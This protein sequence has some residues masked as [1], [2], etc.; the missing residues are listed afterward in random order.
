MA[1][2]FSKIINREIPAEIVYEDEQTLAFLDIRPINSGHM[3][4]VPKHE[5]DQWVDL[6]EETYQSVMATV[7]KMAQLLKDKLQPERVGV[8]IYG[9]DVPHA[10]VHVIPMDQPGD[11]KLVHQEEV[12]P[13]ELAAVR[14][15]LVEE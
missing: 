15:Q 13:K 9:F 12:D 3:L 1:S 6:D 10:H 4:V 5:I 14:R 8:V 7:R 2:I 11:I